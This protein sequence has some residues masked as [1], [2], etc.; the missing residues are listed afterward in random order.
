M[1]S[2][3]RGFV[4]KEFRHIIRDRRTMLILFGMPIAQ[5]I[6]FGFVIRNEIEDVKIAI[7]DQSSDHVSIAVR[8]RIVASRYFTPALE[9][10]SFKSVESAFQSG[11]V[12]L[13]LVFE[14]RFSKRLARDGSATVRLIAD[15]TDPNA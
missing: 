14:P 4:L 8:N 7:V 9:T 12:K 5:L 11:L 10:T 1:Q 2:A 13:A 15:A 6:L 3:F